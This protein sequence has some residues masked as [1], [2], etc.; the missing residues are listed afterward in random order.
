[1][2]PT[3][4]PLMFP[5]RES[6]SGSFPPGTVIHSRANRPIPASASR[7]HL[8]RQ[9]AHNPG[10]SERESHAA[11]KSCWRVRIPTQNTLLMQYTLAPSDTSWEPRSAGNF[12][13]QP[14]KWVHGTEL[15]QY[16]AAMAHGGYVVEVTKKARLKLLPTKDG[17]LR[18]PT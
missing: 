3:N 14:G 1:M 7:A 8:W 6:P 16:A 17:W 12:V 2:T 13:P 15:R 5:L 10:R 11:S 4:N 18:L 9:W